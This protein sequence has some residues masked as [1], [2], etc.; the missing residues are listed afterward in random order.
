MKGCNYHEWRRFKEKAKCQ[1]CGLVQHWSSVFMFETIK[2][3]NKIHTNFSKGASINYRPRKGEK[4]VFE[5]V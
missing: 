4:R 3:I 1:E 5:I 2:Q